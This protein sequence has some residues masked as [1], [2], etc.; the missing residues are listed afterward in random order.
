MQNTMTKL[1]TRVIGV[2]VC[3]DGCAAGDLVVTQ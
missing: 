1:L 2:P 3:S